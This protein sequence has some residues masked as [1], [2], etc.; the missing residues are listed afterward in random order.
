MCI[1]FSRSGMRNVVATDAVAAG[2]NINKKRTNKM[3][4]GANFLLSNQSHPK[5]L[6][7]NRKAGYDKTIGKPA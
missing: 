2:K 1:G 4:F 5:L 3:N 7:Q 6:N